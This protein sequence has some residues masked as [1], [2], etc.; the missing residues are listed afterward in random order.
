MKKFNLSEAKA[1]KKVVTR[2][3]KEVKMLHFTRE[4]ERFPLVAI[5]ENKR[6]ACYTEEGKFFDDENHKQSKNDLFMA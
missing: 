1:G 3:G 6:V 2:E 4:V 5:I